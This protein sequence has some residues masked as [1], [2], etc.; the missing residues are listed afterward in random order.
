MTKR[1]NEFIHAMN[2]FPSFFGWVN[3]KQLENKELKYGGEKE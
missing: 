1:E 3:Q 2:K